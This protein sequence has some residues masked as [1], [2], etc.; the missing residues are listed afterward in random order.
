M[1]IIIPPLYDLWWA[2]PC[3]GSGNILRQM[4]AE[5]RIGFDINPQDNGEFGIIQA[6]F[7]EQLLDP[8]H[9]WG[10]LTNAPFRKMPGDKQGG[11]Q[12]VFA[13]AAD[14]SCVAFIGLIAP[15]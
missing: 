15:H 7:R 9:K 3:A 14:Q 4:P 6:D 1:T 13:W 8:T 12:R 5:R 10:V 2:E 11:P